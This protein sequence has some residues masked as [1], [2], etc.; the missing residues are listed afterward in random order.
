MHY[1]INMYEHICSTLKDP[2]DGVCSESWQTHN[3]SEAES[4]FRLQVEREQGEP[5]RLDPLEGSRLSPRDWD[6]L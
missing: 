3:F 4:A 1:E 2:I 6:L 5:T